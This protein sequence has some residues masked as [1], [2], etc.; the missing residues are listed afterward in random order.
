MF[1]VRLDEIIV[2][3]VKGSWL[4]KTSVC[5]CRNMF[6]AWDVLRMWVFVD[7]TVLHGHILEGFCLRSW[8]QQCK[9]SM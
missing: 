3:G 5:V 1:E 9:Y 6:E 8:L 4:L 7:K 2:I